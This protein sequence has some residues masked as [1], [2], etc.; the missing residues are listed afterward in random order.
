[1][2]TRSSAAAALLA[3]ACVVSAVA[4]P[5]TP[6]PDALLDAVMSP[7]AA[8][9]KGRVMVTQWFG[10]QTRAEEM[11]VYH[12]GDRVRRE[13]LAPDGS[14]ARVAVSDG[15]RAEVREV[16]KGQT[17]AGDAV[18]SYEK[19]MSA[20]D[21]RELLVKNY[22]FDVSGPEKVAGRDCWVLDIEPL[23]DGKAAQK[24]WIDVETKVVLEN[25]RYL[26]G[27]GTASQF[28][29]TRFEPA[30]TLPDELFRLDAGTAAP[31]GKG[32]EPDFMTLE[33]LN[34]ATGRADAI[35]S[36]LAGGFRFESADYFT[37]GKQMVR[38]AR[39]TDGLA[40]VSLF[41]TDKP[42][43]LPRGATRVQVSTRRASMG[44]SAAGRVVQWQHGAAHYT[45]LGDGTRQLL[46]T[47]VSSLK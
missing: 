32:L 4:A 6:E 38:H 21:E 14:I 17:L 22:R 26:P 41:V 10:K 1:M 34:K 9:Y 3:A 27:R 7:P 42:V 24:L 20:D 47:I 44:T 12:S 43:R 16:K 19:K 31:A 25:K 23:V 37:V 2:R 11:E 36:E 8:S 15:E 39:Y 29:F 28:R 45:L 40:V 46:Q 35:P 33:E 5:K 13:F 18:K 30:K